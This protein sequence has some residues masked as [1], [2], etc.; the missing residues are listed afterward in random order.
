MKTF[1][2]FHKTVHVHTG[3]FRKWDSA[4][5]AWAYAANDND[6]LDYSKCTGEQAALNE[7]GKGCTLNDHLIVP[8]TEAEYDAK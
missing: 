5:D 3:R 7:I 1:Y 2:N 6:D 8:I 4:F